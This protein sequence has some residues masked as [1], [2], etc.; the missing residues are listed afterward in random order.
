ML[1]RGEKLKSVEARQNMCVNERE[2]GAEVL[3]NRVQAGLSG[4]R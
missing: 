3:K 2:A 4:W 1:W